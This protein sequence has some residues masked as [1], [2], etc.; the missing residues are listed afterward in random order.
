MHTNFFPFFIDIQFT[1]HTNHA[2]KVCDSVIFSIFIKLQNYH[3]YLT[4]KYFDHPKSNSLPSSS[5]S[6]CLQ[7]LRTSNLHFMSKDI[8]NK[9]NQTICGLLCLAS[10]IL[11]NVSKF[12]I[13]CKM[14]QYFT[15]FYGSM[16]FYCIDTPRFAYPFLS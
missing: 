10:F 13:C 4:P 15:S 12:H 3:P 2:F 11:H 6:P 14:Y 1:Y 9:W 5:H 7:L 16:I 8:S